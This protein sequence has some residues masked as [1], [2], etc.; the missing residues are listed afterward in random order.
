MGT[1][2][3]LFDFHLPPLLLCRDRVV[4]CVRALALWP[5]ELASQNDRQASGHARV[6][7]LVRTQCGGSYCTATRS[8]PPRRA[9]TVHC[10]PTGAWKVSSPSTEDEGVRVPMLHEP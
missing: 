8:E 1:H 2:G 3:A 7:V 6:V 5:L 4:V 10:S 9:V